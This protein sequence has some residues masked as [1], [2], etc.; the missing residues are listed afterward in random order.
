MKLRCICKGNWR[1]IIHESEPLFNR[2]YIDEKGK[3]FIFSGVM[4]SDDDYFYV[5]WSPK[6][7]MFLSCVGSIEGFGYTLR[8][9]REGIEEGT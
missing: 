4:H 8:T 2:V 6:K 9:D 3:E 1:T 5:L 7:T